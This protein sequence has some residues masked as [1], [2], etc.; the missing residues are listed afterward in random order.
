VFYLNFHTHHPGRPSIDVPEAL[1][2]LLQMLG[3]PSAQIPVAIGERRA[4]WWAQLG[5][6]R[7]VVILDDVAK[8]DQVRPLLPPTG[9][10]MILI[11]SR[12]RLPGIESARVLTLDV[13]SIDDAIT[14]F[15]RVAGRGSAYEENEVAAA[16][17]LCGRLPLAIQV[18]AG[19]LAQDFRP[20][21]DALVEKTSRSSVLVDGAGMASPEWIYAFD[22]SYRALEPDHQRFFRRLGM[23]P[24]AHI[25]LDAA[26]ALGGETLAETERALD[27][28]LGHHLLEPAPAGQFRF[29]D[30]IREY[31]ATC[32]GREEPRSEQ[33]QAVGRLL[34]YYLD[35]ADEADRLL[36]PFRH[37]LPGPAPHTPSASP[38]LS[39]HEDAANWLDS[40]W[41]NILQAARYAHQHEWKQK[42]A[43]L[44]HALAGFLEVS[45]Y[46]GEA[47]AAHTLALQAA[48]DA[49]DPAR[50]AQASLDLGEVS[51]QTGRYEAA[52]PLAEDAAAI[53]RSLADRLGEAEALDQIGTARVCMGGF[54]EALA[55][56]RE[57]GIAY[58]DTTDRHGVAR[59]LSHAAIVSWDLGRCSE[60]MA[61]LQEALS[62]FRDIGDRRGQAK[63]L[64][65]LGEMQLHFGHHRDALESYHKS[66]EIFREIGGAQNEAILYCNIGNAYSYTESSEETLAAY[67]RAL[68]IFRSMG[69]IPHEVAVLN[70]IGGI[71][72]RTES[73]DEA[74]IYYQKARLIAQEIGN[75][76]QQVIALR[77][78]ADTRCG[79]GRYG[80]ALDYY[81]TALE[82]ARQIGDPYQEA[83][84]LEGIA[85][86][87]L[88]ERRPDHARIVFRQALDIFERLGVPEAE[89]VQIRI[90][91]MDP[92]RDRQWP[93]SDAAA[94]LG[95]PP[96]RGN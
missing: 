85:E 27:T 16:V 41:R 88:S 68:S 92:S 67:W 90:E 58:H 20:G 89:S 81:H 25:S 21:L 49:A 59:T 40:E 15:R 19:R 65:N 6:R 29:H 11:T 55:Y 94:S 74:L 52:L 62:L 56:F 53:Y 71:Y 22:L 84:V 95:L 39:T 8:P 63:T 70:D 12:N 4:L 14:L 36:H 28:L 48:R 75:R 17:Q 38:A 24:C 37:R 76:Q 83:K 2:R 72:R 7:A 93:H 86:A 9:Q 80:E 43:D 69:D 33:R 77:G 47:I 26:V 1:H 87:T 82:L 51:Q 10:S 42:C 57:A 31:A 60:A 30:L 46:W 5:R 96:E 61:H 3:V 34:D 79:S 32:A 44:T 78:V 54:R 45:A 23:S 66:L 73:Y 18:T 64:N 13:L 91:A 35:A 50:T